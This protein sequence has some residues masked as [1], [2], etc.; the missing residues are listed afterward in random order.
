MPLEP[1]RVCLQEIAAKGPHHRL[2]GQFGF[3]LEGL[4]CNPNSSISLRDTRSEYRRPSSVISIFGEC[5]TSGVL[6]TPII[7][8]PNPRRTTFELFRRPDSTQSNTRSSPSSSDANRHLTST[9]PFGSP[10]APCFTEF[11]VNS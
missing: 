9:L 8:D 3:D 10:S 2:I 4:Y 11:V 6:S 7:S 1:A 5:P